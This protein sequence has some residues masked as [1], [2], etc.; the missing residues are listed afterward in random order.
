MICFFLW[1]TSRHFGMFRNGINLQK[2]LNSKKNCIT[3][4]SL[5]CERV[6]FDSYVVFCANSSLE[7][8]KLYNIVTKANAFMK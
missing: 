8:G 7:V 5:G 3:F 2:P 1:F 6:N 4:V